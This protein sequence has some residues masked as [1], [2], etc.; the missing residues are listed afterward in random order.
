MNNYKKI[1]EHYIKEIDATFTTY[2]HIKTKAKVA[3]IECDDD[4]KVFSIAFR[5]PPIDNS[6]LTHIL[7]HSVLCGSRKYPVKDPFVELL[8]SSLNTFLNAMTFADKTMYPFASKNTKDFNN[9]MDVYMDA[10]FYPNIYEHKE[11]FEQEGWHYHIE[12]KE[13]EIKYNGVVYNEMKGAFSDPS[14]ILARTIKKSLFPDNV[15][16][17]ESGGAQSDRAYV[18]KA[19]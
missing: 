19:L 8:K 6:G 18:D 13:D 2:E 7:E 10:V 17:Y 1:D 11:I 9:L 16:G 14:E 4:N 12:S 15:Y 5:T 3:T